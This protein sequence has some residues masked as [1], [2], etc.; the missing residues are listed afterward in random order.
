MV[1]IFANSGDPDQTLQNVVSDLGL[2]RLP[3]ILLGVSRQQWLSKIYI[4]I[5]SY[6]ILHFSGRLERLVMDGLSRFSAML[7]KG[8]NLFDLLFASLHIRSLLKK[9][10]FVHL[11]SKYFLLYFL[12][13]RKNILDSCL[14]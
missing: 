14:P 7:Y 11:G 12:K 9:E 8:D 2:H 6:M 3:I 10:I 13:G 1:K 5:C 4:V